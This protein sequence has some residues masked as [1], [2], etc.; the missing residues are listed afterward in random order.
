[1]SRILF[2]SEEDLEFPELLDAAAEELA[3][4]SVDRDASRGAFEYGAG[5]AEPLG[6]TLNEGSQVDG[7]SSRVKVPGVSGVRQETVKESYWS[8]P[9]GRVGTKALKSIEEK[10]VTPAKNLLDFGLEHRRKEALKKRERLFSSMRLDTGEGSP[11][12]IVNIGQANLNYPKNYIRTTKYTLL[13]FNP[14]NLFEQFRRYVN[15]YFLFVIV[16][17]FIPGITPFDTPNGIPV[18]SILPLA[19]VVLLSAIKEAFEDYH[20]YLADRS[21]NSTKYQVIREGELKTVPSYDLRVGEIVRLGKDQMCPS[22]IVALFSSHEDN[23]V[24]VETSNLD[25]ETNL[26]RLVA[27]LNSSENGLPQDQE[28]ISKTSSLHGAIKCEAPNASLYKFIGQLELSPETSYSAMYVMDGADGSGRMVDGHMKTSTADTPVQSSTEVDGSQRFPLDAKNLLLRGCRLRNTEYTYGVVVYTG[29]QCKLMLNQQHQRAKFSHVEKKLNTCILSIFY[30]LL[31]LCFIWAICASAVQ[32]NSVWY[33]TG[34]PTNGALIF[35]THLGTFFLLLYNMIPISLIISLELT[36][37]WQKCFMEWDHELTCYDNSVSPPQRKPMLARTSAI[38]DEL[39][40]V[41]HLFSD[42]TGTLTENI[43]EFSKCSVG[44]E[45]FYTKHSS[46]GDHLGELAFTE[47]QTVDSGIYRGT[48]IVTNDGSSNQGRTLE[49]PIEHTSPIVD[50][51]FPFKLEF[52]RAMCVCHTVSP[53]VP[54]QFESG[55]EKKHSWHLKNLK[56]NALRFFK[57]TKADK[58]DKSSKP[59]ETSELT[60]DIEKID[61]AAQSPDEVALVRAARDYGFRLIKRQGQRLHILNEHEK[62][63]EIFQVLDIAEFESS[64]RSMSLIVRTPEGKIVLYSKGAESVMFDKMRDVSLSID[65]GEI[66]TSVAFDQR[67]LISVTK[68]HVQSFADEGLRVLVFGARFLSETEYE[69][70]HSELESAQGSMD[71]SRDL[72]IAQAWELVEHDLTLLGAS[73]VEDRLQY[74]VQET[75]SFLQQAGITIWMVTGD[76][77]ET[78]VAIGVSSS[79]VVDPH[80]MISIEGNTSEQ[81]MQQLEMALK[82]DLLFSSGSGLTTTTDEEANESGDE[83]TPLAG[84]RQFN[85]SKGKWKRRRNGFSSIHTTS[86]TSKRLRGP[87]LVIDG[88]SLTLALKNIPETFLTVAEQCVSVIC[89]RATPLQKAVIVRLVKT[90]G[91]VTCAVGD[92]ANDVSMIQEADVGIGIQGHEGMQAV[93]AS[94]YAIGQFYLLS[95]LL[96]VHGRYNFI[97]AVKLIFYS[98]YK[99]MM[100]VLVQA[101]FAFFNKF[102]GQT[103]IDSWILQFFNLFITS[104]PPLALGTFEKDITETTIMRHPSAYQ[105]LRDSGYFSGKKMLYWSALAIYQSLICFF[106]AYGA[107]HSSNGVERAIGQVGGLW[108]MSTMIFTNVVIIILLEACLYTHYWVWISHV[109]IW[110]SVVFFFVL[111]IAYSYI[112]PND[113]IQQANMYGVVR[114][115]FQSPPYWLSLLATVSLAML[116]DY[117]IRFVMRQYAPKDYE[118]L[119]VIERKEMREDR[120]KDVLESAAN[121]LGGAR[122]FWGTSN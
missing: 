10:L 108:D 116:P 114:W 89:C 90:Q 93:M 18:S 60:D 85:H 35:I 17:Q 122:R 13:T 73:A 31:I 95:R 118:V 41:Q 63:E 29:K 27:V 110:L 20:R 67:D 44:G 40:I 28:I 54:N 76:L 99:N 53:D 96:G 92:G 36:R 82:S 87:T 34:L 24:Y 62:T 56:R 117:V 2:R 113:L 45:L 66:A 25:G 121:V 74:K 37:F 42:K 83:P 14:K 100:L 12:R 30:F 3:A 47:K 70:F 86:D 51:D 101:W 21:S 72:K 104:L 103:I 50:T 43:M 32:D 71:S 48:D 4:A 105:G 112:Q 6:R 106:C 80:K 120:R 97:R 107:Y 52:L 33:L 68:K 81:V 16:V 57:K 5:K 1:M 23:A 49:T 111:M 109:A 9:T 61:Y 88:T 115:A 59:S 8:S 98:L 26:K 78:A 58:A 102:S 22:D 65:R 46:L 19:F 69:N 38:N 64:R 119:Q 55:E 7:A 77:R 75:V 15:L 84:T 11:V 94:D 79:I 39:G 91:R